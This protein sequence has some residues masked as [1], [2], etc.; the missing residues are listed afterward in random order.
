MDDARLLD[1]Y[2]QHQRD[3]GLAA[4]TIHGYRAV[5]VPFVRALHDRGLT[6]AT[7]ERDDIRDWISTRGSTNRTRAIYTTRLRL[8]FEWLQDED[9]RVD[10]PARKIRK[11][12]VP[13]DVPR[14]IDALGL[15]RAL[16]AAD[17]RVGLMISLAAYAGLRRGEITR[18]DRCDILD[19][20]TPPL[21]LVHGKGNKERLVPIG[22]VVATAFA[23]YGLPESGPVFTGRNGRISRG[24]VGSL[25]SRHL[26]SCG[27]NATAH[28]GRHTFGTDL[29]EV[30]QRDL[31]VVQEMM[32]HASP[33]TTAQY[34]AWSPERAAAA[35]NLLPSPPPVA[36]AGGLEVVPEEAA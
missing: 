11:P 5:F 30:S 27:V 1:L 32:G 7:A 21:L 13:R 36:P 16:A 35:I 8:L 6:L 17:T 4:D 22:P 29:Y 19:S 2:T 34:A 20:R 15:Y 24:Y 33:T 18:L 26:R 31:R 23:R 9:Q 28:N 10:N 25:I 12:K 3:R 14:P